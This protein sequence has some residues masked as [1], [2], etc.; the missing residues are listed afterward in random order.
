LKETLASK[1]EKSNK[2]QEQMIDF[3]QVRKL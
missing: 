1:G 3:Q 2:T